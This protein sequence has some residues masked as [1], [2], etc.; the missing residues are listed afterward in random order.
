MLLADSPVTAI[1][2]VSSYFS[3][4]LKNLGILTVRD[5]LYHF[6][7]RYE[8]F[9]R[10]VPIREL[11]EGK[12]CTIRAKVI[13]VSQRRIWKKRMTV[14]EARVEDASGKLTLVWFNQS[15][16]AKSLKEGSTVNFSGK[17]IA[18]RQ[19]LQLI[20]PLYEAV[21]VSETKHTARI[22]PVYPETRGLTSK[23]IRFILQPV[24]REVRVPDILPSRIR[25]EEKLPEANDALQSV[26]FPK[27]L[28]EA[29]RGK[30]RFAF[31]DLLLLALHIAEERAR[32]KKEAAMPVPV[33]V[34]KIKEFLKTIPFELTEAQKRTLWEVVQDM[35]HNHPMHRLIQGDVGSGKTVI[36]ALAMLFAAEKG[37]QSALMA[38]T[39][40]LA[41]QHYRTLIS[42]FGEHG[43]GV[44][45]LVSSEAKI[46]YGEG[47]ET[48]LKKDAF[49]REV[50][51]GNVK[52]VIGTHAVIQRSVSFHSLALAVVDEQHRF[53]VT[54]RATLLRGTHTEHTRKETE[55]KLLYEELTYKIRNSLFNVKK[56]L[57]G[58]HKEIVYQKSLAIE[59]EKNGLEFSREKHI[60]IE[61]Q[62]KKVGTYVPDF[63]VENKVI[64][65]L[66]ALPFTSSTEKKQLWTY[67]KGSSYKL[68]LLANFGPKELIIERI[69]H[70]S[71]YTSVSVPHSSE[72]I[73]HFLSMSATPIPRTLS[74]SVF[75]ELDLSLV[76]ELPK[77][78]KSIETRVVPKEKREDAYRDIRS[79]IKAGRQ[80]FVICPHIEPPAPTPEGIGV[81]TTSVGKEWQFSPKEILELEVKSV[82]EEYEKLSKK[83]FPDLNVAM[84]HGKLKA[85]EKEKIM[86]DF[87]E[88]RTDV[89]VSTSVVE[90]GIDVPNATVM[91]IEDAERFGL[92]QLYQFRGRVGRGAHQ[93]YCFLLTQKDDEE[94]RERLSYLERAKNGFELAEFDLKT[95]GPG[96]LFGVAQSGVPDLAMK[97]LQNPE[98]LRRAKYWCDELLKEDATLK[99]HPLLC[100]RLKEFAKEIHPE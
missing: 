87:A 81:P 10:I 17:V 48:T 75:G 47:L 71:E 64:L 66:K 54:Q 33:S 62:G 41:R 90:V 7:Y 39:E 74:L 86:N 36:A 61:Y 85:T 19:I 69:I 1:K 35:G 80:A 97:A 23:G 57:G 63:I 45:L 72:F 77:N 55:R 22:V 42:L 26:H 67:L 60:T 2:G 37:Y 3:S 53:G 56:E 92:A 28:G 46:Y 30:K 12:T 15:Y 9:S 43:H 78:R 100:E 88:G 21:G 73:P 95:R 32:A 51:A 65:E 68:A 11:A 24:L 93:S 29:F 52:M 34:E 59:F 58:G 8:D 5:L 27:T 99:S 94:T 96:E 14:T 50:K 13:K 70:D 25:E 84:L 44:G 98:M 49:L 18:R 82:K 4:R 79:Q 6:P 91:M 38:P 31:E 76:D 40:I 89:L 20:N 83:I 16:I